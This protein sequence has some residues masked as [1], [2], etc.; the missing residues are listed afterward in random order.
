MSHVNPPLNA[1]TSPWWKIG[2]LSLIQSKF[3]GTILPPSS[4]LNPIEFRLLREPTLI[5]SRMNFS[6]SIESF[7]IPTPFPKTSHTSVT[8]HPTGDVSKLKFLSPALPRQSPFGLSFSH[9]LSQVYDMFVHKLGF[10]LKMI[11]P[12]ARLKYPNT[13]GG[14]TEASF[15]LVSCSLLTVEKQIKA[16]SYKLIIFGSLRQT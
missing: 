11:C 2:C 12:Q 5:C 16:D 15:T 9:S 4:W 8:I 7:G 14:T 6:T 3:F 13:S 10:F 1:S